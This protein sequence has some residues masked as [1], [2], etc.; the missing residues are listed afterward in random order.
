MRKHGTTSWEAIRAALLV[1]AALGMSGCEQGETGTTAQAQLQKPTL[2]A[3]LPEFVATPD[4]M[5]IDPEGNLIA[6]CPNFADQTKP[7]CLIKVD[8]D[9]RVSKW[10][11]VPVLPE[12]GLACPMGIEFGPDGDIYVCDNQGWSGS[13]KGAFKGRMLRLRIKDNKVVKTT[14]VA[15]GMEHP[16]GCR[17]R[18]GGLYVTQS[19]M[20]KVKDP[21]GLMVSVVYRFKLDDENVKVANTL[22]DKNIITKLLTQNKF[23]QYGADGIVFDSKGN[24]YIGNFGDGT[25]YKI[26]FDAAGNVTGNTVFAKTD[27]DYALDPKAP[28]FLDKAVK[29]KMRTTDGIC[30]D[31]QDNLYVADFSNNAIAKV[32]PDGTISVLA[33][34]ADLGGRNGALNEPGEPCV[35]NG[36]IAVTNFDAVFGPDNPDKV[37]KSHE[38]PATMSALKLK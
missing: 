11:D 23:C 8:K 38:M 10:V 3:V 28:G 6:A 34:N 17:V 32:T 19:L 13:A 15:E 22:D 30:V 1:A 33:Q 27:L 4:G 25:I 21:S 12:T 24:L 5:A 20:T 31:A 36:I 37:N 35:W 26:T 9:K 16:N 7:G 18:N 29:A 2:L 14:V